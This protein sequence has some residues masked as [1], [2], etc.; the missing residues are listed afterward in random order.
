MGID[1]K[2]FY[3][4]TDLPDRYEYM[5]I[6]VKQIPKKIFEQYNLEPLVHKGAVYVEI[7]K[8]MYGLPHAGKIANNK[9][10][11]ILEANGYQQAP[12]TP[13]LFKHKTRP[14]AFCLIVDD[15]GVKYVGK[16]H[17]QH[18]IG[19][20]ESAGYEATLDWEGK[21]F[22]GLHLQWDYEN[23]TVD[24][25]MPGYIEKA[26]QRFEHPTPTRP[27]DAPHAWQAPQYGAKI[28]MTD[29]IDT[30][31][32]LDP[33]GTKRLQEIIGTLLYYA[34]TVDSTMLVAL[35][36][37]AAAQSK[38]TEET[39][40]AS[41]KLL[42]YA[43]THPDAV[44][45]YT[46]SDMILH[47]YSDASYLSETEA[48]SRAGGIFFLSHNIDTSSPNA[49]PPRINGA[50][51][52]ISKI[53]NNVLASATEAEVGA[54]FHNAQDRCMIRN[55]LQFLGHPQPATPIQ[56]DNSCAEGI[57]NDTVKQRCSKAI[58]MRFYWVR[59]RV[60]QGQFNIHW[61]RG[62]DNLADYFTKHFPASHHREMRPIYLHEKALKAIS[63]QGLVHCE[64]V[65]ISHSSSPSSNEP[66]PFVAA[67]QGLNCPVQ[68]P[69]FP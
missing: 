15:F 18:L 27:E 60:K 62:Q 63:P 7:R 16:E 22:C 3:L 25:S 26:L 58:D 33:T 5:R 56:T 46:A 24:L 1:L 4:G 52:I 49:P 11:N 65:L 13:G 57:I 14:I 61:K 2:D 47:I 21:V 28:Q 64:G 54:L 29:E 38:G 42:N 44:L 6:P 40:K 9:L 43:A 37:L 51:H 59:D 39:A 36:T 12:H 31:P 48:R 23:G 41:I 55:A 30:S 34:R 53:M 67:R 20:I 17:A 8:G 45:R 32:P 50:I 19:V 10:C 66:S 68:A 35:G 69:H